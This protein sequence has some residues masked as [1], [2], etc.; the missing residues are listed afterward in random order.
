MSLWCVEGVYTTS[1][2]GSNCVLKKGQQWSGSFRYIY[3]VP[4][5]LSYACQVGKVGRRG[6]FNLCSSLMWWRI[7]CQ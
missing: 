6:P 7:H 5:F 3:I 2:V 4:R 1:G